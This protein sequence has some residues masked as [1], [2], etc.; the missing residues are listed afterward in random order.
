MKKKNG[1]QSGDVTQR[2]M[3][4]LRSA[5]ER[6]KRSLNKLKVERLKKNCFKSSVTK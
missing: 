1:K 6:E 2:Q 4:D 5:N 3:R